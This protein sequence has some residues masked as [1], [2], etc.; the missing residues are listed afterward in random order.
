M[1]ATFVQIIIERDPMTKIPKLAAPWEVP[2]YR[3]QYGDEKV[4]V[5]NDTV[6]VEIS[7]LPDATEEYMRIREV[8]GIEPDTKQSHADVVYGRGQPGIDMLEK[9]IKASISTGKKA[10]AGEAA[11]EGAQKVVDGPNGP[12]D[13][14]LE[15]RE[16]AQDKDSEL[17]DQRSNRDV[18]QREPMGIAKVI[19]DAADANS[20][21]SADEANATLL[22]AGKAAAESLAK[23]APVNPPAPAF[24]NAEP[25]PKADT[26]A[27]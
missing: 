9:A 13:D 11:I 18:G 27:K 22:A 5:L 20:G 16:K 1:K 14:V 10:K 4:E 12:G 17:V 23:D 7:E 8:F 25:T 26:K 3:S 19:A 6:D 24:T 21:K 2:V 15:R